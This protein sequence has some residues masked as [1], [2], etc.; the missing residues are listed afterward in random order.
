MPSEEIST[1]HTSVQWVNDLREIIDEINE[2]REEINK[3]RE[4]REKKNNVRQKSAE[5]FTQIQAE[6]I[7]V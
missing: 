1:G 4:E 3:K 5:R 2:K 7:P 6:I